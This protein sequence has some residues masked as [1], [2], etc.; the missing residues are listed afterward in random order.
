M[1]SASINMTVSNPA[2]QPPAA[3]VYVGVSAQLDITLQNETGGA[4]TFNAGASP[5]KLTIFMP[6]F[7]TATQLQQMQVNLASWNYSYSSSQQ[8]LILTYAGASGQTWNSEATLAFSI[9]SA[10]STNT[11][12]SD[13]IQINPTNMTGNVPIQ[14]SAPLSLNNAPQPGNATLPLQ[15]WLDAQGSVYVSQ[16]GD[17]LQNTLFLNFKNTSNNPLW[18]GT[19]LWTGN[20]QVIVS[21]VYGNSSGALAPDSDKS[22]PQTGSAWKI[23]GAVSISQGNDWQVTN[24]SNSAEYPH[25]FWTLTPANN[26]IGIIGTGA[27][28][29]LSFD[30]SQIVSCTPPGATQMVVQFTGFKKDAQTLYN[31]AVFVLNISKQNP[32]PTRGLLN[33]FS[34]QSP[35]VTVNSPTQAININLKWTMFNVASV[36]LICSFPGVAPIT[37][38]YPNFQPLGY[39]TTTITLPGTPENTAV[40]FTLQAFSGKGVYLNSLQY[41]VFITAQIFVDPR[42]GKEYPTLQ[43]N[44]TLWMTTNLDWNATGSSVYNDDSNNEATY[45]RLYTAALAKQVPVGWRLPSQTDWNNLIAAYTSSTDSTAAYKA[46]VAGGSSGFNAQLGG[47]ENTQKE[48]SDLGCKGYYWTSSD[49]NSSDTYYAQFSAASQSITTQAVYPTNYLISVRYVKDIS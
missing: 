21:F 18:T 3:I 48:Y 23:S 25:P 26:N 27:N 1:V 2:I 24:P 14:V 8:A 29:N 5:S 4:I 46:L 6:S 42:D 34:E 38:S 41:T 9:T 43:V 31:D 37:I 49:E 19:T 40:F 33:F 36:T 10:T 15:V 35:L 45:G 32:P 12:T 44:N 16:Q 17:P 28:A 7:Y 39:D 22:S 30:F 20:P 13:T 47:S 11:P